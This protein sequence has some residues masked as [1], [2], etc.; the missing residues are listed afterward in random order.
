[1]SNMTQDEWEANY[2]RSHER[3]PDWWCIASRRTMAYEAYVRGNNLD[4]SLRRAGEWMHTH[5]GKKFF[6]R[7]PHPEDICIDDIANGLA[8]DCR[9]GG[10]GRVDRYYSVA[11]HCWH[12]ARHARLMDEMPP[13]VC[14]AALLHDAPEAYLNDLPRAVK[15]SIGSVYGILEESLQDVINAKYG[16]TDAASWHGPRGFGAYIKDLD[17]RIVS[18]E[19]YAIM[20]TDQEWAYDKFEPLPDVHIWCLTPARAKGAFLAEYSLISLL[21]EDHTNGRPET[22]TK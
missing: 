19:K 7:D 20:L 3:A 2:E 1:M 8:L 15:H 10:Q 6:P 11:E 18:N 5:S 9:Y 4:T 16:C 17:C 22:E 14:M 12:I 13:E 21:M